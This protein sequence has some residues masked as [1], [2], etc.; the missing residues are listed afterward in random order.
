MV[1]TLHTLH[2]NCKRNC[3]M[4]RGNW[5]LGLPGKSEPSPNIYFIGGY[6]TLNK[7]RDPRFSKYNTKRFELP[8]FWTVGRED[9]KVGVACCTENCLHTE[10]VME[11]VIVI[12]NMSI[13]NTTCF[14]EYGDKTEV[15]EL[16]LQVICFSLI[17]CIG[18]TYLSISFDDN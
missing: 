17:C 8:T 6:G 1:V 18:L 5:E 13:Q 9:L 4:S 15:L 7:K 16:V 10:L 3:I 11:A 14:R 2:T 12:S